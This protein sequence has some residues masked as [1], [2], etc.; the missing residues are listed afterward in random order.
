MP[1]LPPMVPTKNVVIADYLSFIDY[2]TQL[3][4]Q[5]AKAKTAN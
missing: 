3:V 2:L 4:P 5:L 1:I